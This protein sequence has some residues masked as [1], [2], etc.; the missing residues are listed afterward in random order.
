MED[1]I[2][3]SIPLMISTVVSIILYRKLDPRW[4]RLFPWFLAITFIIQ[5]GGFYYS[6][7]FKKSNHFIF[8]SY[9]LIE[10]VFYIFIFYKAL[11]NKRL[12]N[13]VFIILLAFIIIYFFEIFLFNNYFV[14]NGFAR[15]IGQFLTFCCCL[16]YL[17]EL[18]SSSKSINYFTI[19]M[20]WITT[21]IMLA[22]VGNFAYLSFFD[23]IMENNLDPNGEV[24]GI[25]TTSLSIL[26]YGLF[27]FGFLCKNIWIKAK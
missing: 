21:G 1:L 18:L 16:L 8:N 23:Y 5:A 20:F 26:E 4:L 10:H 27:T 7:I 13:F 2:I 25:I 12:K 3:G 19:P 14:Y 9:I 6:H 22:T 11:E 15:N 24:Y 17:F